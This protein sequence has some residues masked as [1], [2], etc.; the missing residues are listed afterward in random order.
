MRILKTVL[1]VIVAIILLLFIISLFLPSKLVFENSVNISA[2]NSTVYPLVLNYQNWEKWDPWVK[3]DKDMKNTYTGVPGIGHK[4]TWES[5]KQGNG[6][7][8][9]VEAE[10]NKRIKAKL[11]FQ[12]SGKPAWD[13]WQFDETPEG[14]KVTW[15]IEVETGF[16]PIVKYMFAFT[17]GKMNKVFKD[18]LDNLKTLAESLPETPE[19]SVI[20]QPLMPQKYIGIKK[21]IGFN[22]SEIHAFMAESY[23]AIMTFIQKNNI[24]CT[25]PL[26]SFYFSYDENM[27]TMEAMPAVPVP[28]E[29][30]VRLPDGM[31]YHDIAPGNSVMVIHI[32]AYEGLASAWNALEKY[33][34]DK[35]LEVNGAPFEV[36]LTDPNVD[37]DTAHWQTQ[38]VFPIK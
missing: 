29:T 37:K 7:M 18:G 4:R 36:Y 22:P 19:V 6:S 8:E 15:K 28:L 11:M 34:K 23:Q 16:N 2:K 32:G 30:N 5:K 1:Y 38:V 31:Q 10:T 27:K 25:G 24:Q 3:A 33:I 12:D 14:T 9:I 17:K 35:N 21:T 26:A 20:E 13:N